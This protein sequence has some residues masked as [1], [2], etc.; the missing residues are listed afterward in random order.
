MQVLYFAR[1]DKKSVEVCAVAPSL[2]KISEA[3][4]VD[5][6]NQIHGSMPLHVLQKVQILQSKKIMDWQL[7]I[8]NFKDHQD[9]V[10]RLTRKGYKGI[11]STL[12]PIISGMQNE[13]QKIEYKPAKTMLRKKS[14]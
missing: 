6:I 7:Y 8:E 9:F 10:L 5:D 11:P 13:F 1:R 3:V 4:M 2:T 14:K 12:T